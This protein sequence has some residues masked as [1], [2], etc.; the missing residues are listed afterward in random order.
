MSADS[1]DPHLLIELVGLLR[2]SS[3]SDVEQASNNLDTLLA[4]L[5]EDDK[6]RQVLKDYAYAIFSSR[7]SIRAFTEVGV[8]SSRSFYTETIRKISNEILPPSYPE[9]GLMQDLF[10]MFRK[11]R[12]YRWVE[13]IATEKWAGLFELLGYQEPYSLPAGSPALHQ[14]LNC[15]L[16]LSQRITGIGL[17]PAIVEKMPE[18]ELFDSPFIV[19]SREISAYLAYFDDPDFERNTENTDYQHILVMLNQCED[20][21]QLIR[22]NKKKFGTSLALSRYMIQLTQNI[23]RLRM[24]LKLVH[25]TEGTFPFEDEA[26]FFQQLVRAENK[27]RSLR[28]HLNQNLAYLAFHITEHT[29]KKGERYITTTRPEYWRMFRSA[30]GGGFIVGFLAIIK[31]IFSNQTLAPFSRAFLYSMNYSLGF[32]L[33]HI[34]HSTLA[35]KQPAMTASRVAASLDISKV[36]EKNMKNLVEMLVRLSRSQ[37]IAFVG[38]IIL[39]F[40]IAYG[41]A[42]GVEN[43]TGTRFADEPVAKK[44]IYELHPFESLALFHAAIAGV[45]LF[46]SGLISGYYDNKNLYSKIPKRIKEHR[47]LRRLFPQRRIDAFANYIDNN[48]GALAGNFFLGIFL[49]STG[50]V[51]YVLGL[52]LDIRH[53]AFA[54]GNFGISLAGMEA[55]FDTSMIL[56]SLLG[57]FLIGFINFIVSFGLTTL[58]AIKSRNVDF[59]GTSLLI[60]LLFKRF[61]TWPLDFFWAPKHPHGELLFEEESSTPFKERDTNTG[62]KS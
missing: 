53:V 4:I 32:I 11:K 46:L 14:L 24:F 48:L 2:P 13:G 57:I 54:S 26:I 8:Q 30:L 52:P 41:I 5:R 55:P 50:T 3:S 60:K 23:K 12:D 40:P 22:K 35:T 15:I 43:F 29:G 21:I 31:T 9:N 17:E 45:Y 18:I 56:Y 44:I 62:E 19:Q 1:S 42:W 6:L 49:G 36:K 58:M 38:N 33:I 7:N 61:F 34:T 16:V 28:A 47:I 51:G 27:K 37:F 10:H 59:K 39:A 25:F 20:Y